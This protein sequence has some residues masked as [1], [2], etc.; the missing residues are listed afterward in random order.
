LNFFESTNSR[1]VQSQ[2]FYREEPAEE[3]AYSNIAVRVPDVQAAIAEMKQKGYQ[4]IDQEAKI[5][6]RQR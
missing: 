3:A 6:R 5:R 1:P 2:S 4:M